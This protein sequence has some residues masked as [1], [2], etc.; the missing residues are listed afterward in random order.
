MA[1]D[2]R[3]FASYLR[4]KEVL[5]DAMGHLYRAGEFDSGGFIRAVWL[6]VFDGPGVPVEDVI[7]ALDRARQIADAAQ[8][9]SVAAGFDGVVD[10]GVP[11]IANDYTPSKPLSVILERAAEERF[12]VPVDNALLI[13]EK[14]SIALTATSTL[15]ID[16]ERVVHGLLHPGLIL[17]THDGESQVTGFGIA[18]QLLPL[19]EEAAAVDS[20]HPYLAPEVIASRTPGRRGDVYS[21]GAILF[22]L[23]T[24]RPLPTAVA[25]RG[26]ALE[27][28]QLGDGDGPLPD[29]IRGLLQRSLAE[30]PEQ[31]F[32]SAADFKKELDRLLYG[33]AYSPTTF[34]LALFMDRLFRAEIEAEERELAA[35]RKVDITPYLDTAVETQPAIDE[36]T[37]VA[38]PTT[39]RRGLWIA[40]GAAAVIAV[41]VVV[42]TLVVGR[43]PSTASLPPTPT[44]EEIEA[45]REAQDAKMRELAED[46]VAEM[47]AEKEQEIRQELSERQAK[48]DELQRRLEASE[49]RAR[50]GQL[51]G[52]EA[53][54]REELQRQIAAEEQAQRQQ[55]ADLAA[56]R[57]RVAEEAR[58]QL[59]TDDGGLAG[60]STGDETATMSGE[61]TDEA[62]SPKTQAAVA[63]EL[64][65]AVPTARPTP[66]PT[67]PPTSTPI[68]PRVQTND[69]VDPTDVDSLPVV[70]KEEEVVWPRTALMSRRQGVVIIRAT[71]N[72]DGLVED[73]EVLRA[74]HDGFG[75]PQAVSDAAMRYRFKPGTKDGVRIKTHATI[76]K[77]YHFVVR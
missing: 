77:R 40:A 57:E 1:Q 31:R 30:Q 61:T 12:P 39:S 41:A 32:S 68:A 36:F 43:G 17:V 53:R 60:V 55:E 25:G 66:I 18:P 54:R 34:N 23:L 10:G 7:A 44:A 73:V 13:L 76:T 6:R 27:T 51:T 3:P 62:A 58:A 29:D 28:A 4:F 50:E 49:R 21:L 59:V 72:A 37:E 45:Q 48:I 42:G 75:I 47:M 56:E 35:E 16:G 14:I 65:T 11:A 46:L 9:T 26:K 74:D 33:G 22:H 64:P 15:E 24:G 8:S 2:Y 67:P 69:F 38:A 20:L 63:T 70:I 19:A 5:A 52:A 71:V